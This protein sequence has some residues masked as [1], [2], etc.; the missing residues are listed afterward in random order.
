MYSDK[1]LKTLEN[2]LYVVPIW[3]GDSLVRKE[4]IFVSRITKS[5]ILTK[6]LEGFVFDKP[7]MIDGYKIN[8]NSALF[9][10]NLDQI[11]VIDEENIEN[12]SPENIRLYKNSPFFK[13]KEKPTL[14]S[15]NEDMKYRAYLI[16]DTE[17]CDYTIGCA[18]TVIEIE[19]SSLEEAEKSLKKEI[20]ETYSG[21]SE[22]R[23]KS[24]ELYE[25]KNIISI[26]LDSLYREEEE[27]EEKEKEKEKEE[28][29]KQEL[30]RLQ[31]KYGK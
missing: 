5:I 11:Q 19:A 20:N 7:E 26:D 16:Q 13:E 27:A 12:N 29:E 14:I 9:F 25:I 24:A 10:H 1:Y 15:K 8:F 22:W 21:E 28:A 30:L 4:V 6:E 3:Q 17:G 31:K 18:Q 2:K 23:L